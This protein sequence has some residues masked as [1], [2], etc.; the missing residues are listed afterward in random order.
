MPGTHNALQAD[1]GA[2][3][4]SKIAL[5]CRLRELA[6]FS[7]FNRPAA[8]FAEIIPNQYVPAPKIFSG[9]VRSELY[10]CP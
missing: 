1:G 7:V 4:L 8:E 2:S 3:V 5:F 9:S 6:G 10:F